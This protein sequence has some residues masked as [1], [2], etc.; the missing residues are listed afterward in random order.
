MSVVCPNSQCRNVN[1][2]RTTLPSDANYCFVCGRAVSDKAK[3][4][5]KKELD[6]IR[7]KKLNDANAKILL[8]DTQLS[9]VNRNNSKLET[10]LK[11]ANAEKQYL[12]IQ[13]DNEVT[14]NLMDNQEQYLIIPNWAYW[15]FMII[16]FVFIILLFASIKK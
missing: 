13:L 12:K 1:R 8:L 10:D 6:N 2:E 3:D 16:G 9:E 14:E 7:N 4:K 15:I 11:V 5:Q